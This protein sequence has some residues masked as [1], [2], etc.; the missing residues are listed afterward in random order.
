MATNAAICRFG[1]PGATQ[2]YNPF[3]MAGDDAVNAQIERILHSETFRNAEALRRLLRFL[4]EKSLSGEADQL[5]EYTIGIDALG[6][7][8]TYDPRQD[9]VVRIQVSRLRQKLADYYRD[10]GRDDPIVFDLPKG[11]FKLSW[12]ERTNGGSAPGA[13]YPSGTGLRAA[14]TRAKVLIAAGAGLVILLWAVTATVWLSREQGETA[15]FRTTCTPELEELWQPFLKSDRPTVVSVSLPLFVAMEGA[16]LY[17][18]L[19]LNQWEDVE[20]SPKVEA[21]RKALGSP[22]IYPRYDYVGAGVVNSVFHLGKLLAFSDLKFSLARSNQISWQQMAGNNVI[23]IGGAR[24]LAERL[25]GL[26]V[27]LP[28]RLD[29]RGVQ[30]V[31]PPAGQPALLV[32]DYPSITGASSP[33]QPDDG[34]IHAIVTHAPGPLG[35][36]EVRAFFSNHSP[37]TWGAVQA[38][39]DPAMAAAIIGGLRKPTG[40][41]PRYYQVVL[42]VKYREAVPTDVAYVLHRELAPSQSTAGTAP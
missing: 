22:G 21:V 18:D 25:R 4:A 14:G 37:G 29:E 7:P 9:S 20:K 26:P 8:A 42:K 16:G 41:I 33:N 32:D 27:E 5:K 36:S 11:R 38:F 2:W 40:R 24:A 15:R 10:E 12:E 39:T 31:N 30:N 19:A 6:K 35:G 13:L 34:E 23:L 1:R 3:K 17:R 28:L